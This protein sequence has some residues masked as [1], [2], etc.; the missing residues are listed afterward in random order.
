MTE[1]RRA[2]IDRAIADFEARGESWT[3]QKVYAVVGG[4]YAQLSEYLKELRAL[5]G[6][7]AGLEE[8]GE[9]PPGGEIEEESP[10]PPAHMLVRP[11]VA[12][13]TARLLAEPIIP[14]W[15]PAHATRRAMYAQWLTLSQAAGELHTLQ[16]AVDEATLAV[17]L[18]EGRR[19]LGLLLPVDPRLDDARQAAQALKEPYERAWETWSQASRTLAAMRPRLNEERQRAI[20]A[21]QNH[22][23]ER[24]YPAIVE[25][26][27]AVTRRIALGNGSRGF[28]LVL[29]ET[30]ARLF[31]HRPEAPTWASDGPLDDLPPAL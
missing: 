16:K 19:R 23:L 14:D 15:R 22:W 30:R 4:S 13:V 6:V 3:N 1:E 10:A 7:G 11:S 29:Q 8:P 26:I 24:Q 21:A 31:A 20:T 18:A 2:E 5:A 28:E 12:D 17:V 25:E 9:I 27:H